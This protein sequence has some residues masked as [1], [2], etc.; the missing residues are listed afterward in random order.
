MPTAIITAIA[1]RTATTYLRDTTALAN[2][3]TYS[4]GK[5]R[6]MYASGTEHTRIV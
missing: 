3:V 5:I 1:P 2:R 4:A 6:S